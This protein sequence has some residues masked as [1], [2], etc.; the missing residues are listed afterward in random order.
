[1]EHMMMR[2]YPAEVDGQWHVDA[3][4][5]GPWW[6]CDIPFGLPD[7]ETGEKTAKAI[8]DEHNAQYDSWQR[9]TPAQSEAAIREASK[10]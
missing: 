8:C 10:I 4:S 5:E 1:M 3:G 9:K 6:V 2:W 7:D